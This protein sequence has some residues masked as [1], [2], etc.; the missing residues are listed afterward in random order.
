MN[1]LAWLAVGIACGG[2][3]CGGGGTDMPG[4]G[5]ISGDGTTGGGDGSTVT[6]CNPAKPFG[7]PV[8]VDELNSLLDDQTPTL[9]ADELTVLFASNRGGGAGGL[10]LYI[11]T[12]PSR[13]GVWTTP[14]PLGGVNT[15]ANQ[16]RPML[17]ADGLTLYAETTTGSDW[18]LSKA[19]R[20]TPQGTFGAL[21]AEPV[22][23]GNTFDMSPSVL[24]DGSAIFF[25]SDRNGS[26]DLYR[27]ARAGATWA[28]PALVPGP[29][30]NSSDYS[31]S[32][33]LI[34][35]DALTLYFASDR[36]GGLGL[37]D[38]YVAKRATP[39]SPFDDPVL[40]TELSTAANDLPSWLSSDGCEL[41][42]SRVVPSA[43][44]ELLAARRPR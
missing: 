35:A 44:Q 42:L 41:W 24:P 22:I 33:P 1:R 18:N 3:G 14:A 13:A 29:N 23:N 11:A 16:S 40:V 27:A 39:T 26:N 25:V 21:Q 37:L 7:A 4:D 17:T 15:A 2:I 31:E 36:P 32:Y 9:T 34:S 19:T 10:D 43:G 20:A 5:S 6:G 28:A 8:A 30:V 12:R 38:I